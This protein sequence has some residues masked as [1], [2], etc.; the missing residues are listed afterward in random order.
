MID[1]A[2]PDVL[3][4]DRHR[5]AGRHTVIVGAGH[6]AATTLLAL[7]ELADAGTGHP[8]HLGHPRQTPTEPRRRRRRRAARPRQ[9]SVSGL[10]LLVDTGRVELAPASDQCTPTARETSG[11]PSATEGSDGRTLVADH[12]VAATG[13]R[14]DHSIADELRLDLDPTSA[15]PAHW[16]PLIDP[17]VHSCGTVRRTASTSSPT[18]S[19]ASTSSA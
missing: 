18:R 12:V 10:Q 15:P 19:R 6:S 9:P 7:S 2:L 17:N 1:H 11:S 4:A 5:F 13:Y 3:G 16:R 8:D 14:P